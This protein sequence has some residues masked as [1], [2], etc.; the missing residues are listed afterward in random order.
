MSWSDHPKR[1]VEVRA[2]SETLESVSPGITENVRRELEA[3]GPDVMTAAIEK[4]REMGLFGGQYHTDGVD[5]SP[6]GIEQVRAELAEQRNQMLNAGVMEQSMLLTH[7]LV[8]LAE[9]K[10]VKECQTKMPEALRALKD[11]AQEDL[12]NME[13]G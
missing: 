2:A 9:L 3:Y 8:L 1:M 13:K 12:K 6:E 10:D 4:C 5:N 11:Q 7:V